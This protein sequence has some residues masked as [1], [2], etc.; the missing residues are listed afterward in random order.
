MIYALETARLEDGHKTP[1]RHVH[2]R[3]GCR[4]IRPRAWRRASLRASVPG[5][6]HAPLPLKKGPT[7]AGSAVTTSGCQ[8]GSSSRWIS[9]PAK[10]RLPIDGGWRLC[11]TS[12][13]PS[14]ATLEGQVTGN[15]PKDCP[16]PAPHVERYIY[17]YYS[18]QRW[19]VWLVAL[20]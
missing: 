18:K 1:S 16:H 13:T 4:A 12:T 6:D 20:L 3:K 2:E 15:G 5:I 7:P 19:D 14:S 11:T 10:D 9:T 17:Q 8:S